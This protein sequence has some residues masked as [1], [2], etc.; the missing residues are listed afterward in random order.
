MRRKI[1]K[2]YSLNFKREVVRR[3]VAAQ[4]LGHSAKAI[5]DL[6]GLPGQTVYAWMNS[7][8]AGQSFK[9]APLMMLRGEEN[10]LDQA[11]AVITDTLGHSL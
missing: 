11:K 7:I 3:A 1:N 9:N 5:A 2:R 6:H 10:I 4:Q 8:R